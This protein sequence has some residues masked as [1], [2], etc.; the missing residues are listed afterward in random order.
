MT[1]GIVIEE[2]MGTHTANA[3][4]GDF[5]VGAMGYIYKN[6]TKGPFQG[7]MFSGNIFE[8]FNNIKETGTD[9]TWQGSF[10]SPSLYIE[11]LKISGT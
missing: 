5:S 3:I 1:N 8:M 10:A 6:G 9:L 11:G 2:L 7:V 4:T